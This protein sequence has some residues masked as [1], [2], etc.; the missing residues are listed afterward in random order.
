MAAGM[1]E[2]TLSAVA[3]GEIFH[4]FKGDLHNGYK[5]QLRDTFADFDSECG[6]TAV[7]ARYQQLP[8]IVRIDQADQ[9]AQY[10]AVFMA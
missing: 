6:V 5:H 7:P 4:L 2:T 3:F 8:L 10:N 1:P 9:I